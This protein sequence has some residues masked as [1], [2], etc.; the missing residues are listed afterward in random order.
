MCL[1][2][3]RINYHQLHFTHEL[4]WIFEQIFE[5]DNSDKFRARQQNYKFVSLHIPNTVNQIKSNKTI[6]YIYK[7]HGGSCGN[8]I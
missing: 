5:E 6:N 7:D 2:R 4:M 3:S 1:L 8:Q